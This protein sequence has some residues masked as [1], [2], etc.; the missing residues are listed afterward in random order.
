MLA[1]AVRDYAV[2]WGVAPGER[3][4]IVTN[5][6]DA[7]RTAMA[8]HEAGL[9]VPAILDARTKGGGELAEKA[10]ER[11]IRVE[12]GMGIAK[13]KGGATVEG[14]TICSQ[15]GGGA[16]IEDIACDA[17]AMSG[18]WSPVVHLWSHC[19]GKL[20]WDEA[21]AH[22][23]PD[24]RPPAHGRGRAGLRDG[25]GRRF[26]RAHHG[27]RARRCPRRRGAAAGVKPKGKL[28]AV[29]EPAEAPLVPV[30]LM[31][32]GAGDGSRPR[33]GSTSRTT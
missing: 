7:Y 26:R 27:G 28:P 30:W 18:G 17:I 31:P 24:P 14:V 1:S 13:V 11:G 6:D 3:T 19:G 8:L 2:N 4:V 22:F 29:E 25:R 5:N 23:R 10:R 33:C 21:Q 32:Q 20:V 9:A 15:M 12:N 16:G